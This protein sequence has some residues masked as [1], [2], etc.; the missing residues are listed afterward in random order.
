MTLDINFADVRVGELKKTCTRCDAALA[1]WRSPWT[2]CY[3]PMW[4]NNVWGGDSHE[5]RGFLCQKCAEDLLTPSP[6]A[7]E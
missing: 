2:I 1:D 3:D 5:Y 6:K 7:V 4:E